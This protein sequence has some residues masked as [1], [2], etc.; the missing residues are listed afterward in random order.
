M[1]N[2]IK[3]SK[4]IN[5]VI[6][7]VGVLLFLTLLVYW[8]NVALLTYSHPTDHFSIEYP[9]QWV[10][11]ENKDGA[12]V[13]FIS[14]KQNS[15]DTFQENVN[16]VIQDLGETPM[17]LGKYTETAIFQMKVVFKASLQEVE[18]KGTYL[19]GHPAY[20]FAY[21]IKGS[22]EIKMMHVW[23]IERGKA[24]QVTCVALSSQF[25]EYDINFEKM[26]NSFHIR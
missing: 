11:M 20:R 26:I 1:E 15:L 21:L 4:L 18:S 19:D 22:P 8:G 10:K 12:S 5:K 14:P 24:Y 17:S 6:I 3:Q 16:V 25:D 9:S 13:V 7:I 2:R 23:T